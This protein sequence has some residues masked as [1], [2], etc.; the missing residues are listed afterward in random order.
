MRTTFF[1][2]VLIIACLWMS[3]AWGQASSRPCSE[4]EE[5]GPACLIGHRN[6]SAVRSEPLFW[7]LETFRSVRAAQRAAGPNGTVVTAYGKTWLFTI[8]RRQWRS[9]GGKH[10]AAIGPLAL[11]PAPAYSVHYL[12]AVFNPGMTAPLHV[13][14]GPEAFYALTGDSCLETP[15]GAQVARGRGNQLLV[16]GGPPMLL[17]ALGTV[18]RRGFA[19]IVHDARRPAT[20]LINDWKPEGLCAREFARERGERFDALRPPLPTNTGTVPPSAGADA[21]ALEAIPREFS[22]AWANGDG[23]A[24][25]R[26]MASDV[27]FVTVGA[28]WLHGRRDF[29]LYHSRLFEGRFRGSII[30]PLQTRVRFIRPDLAIVRWSWRIA[31]DRSPDGSLQQARVGLMSMLVEKRQ[32]HWLVIGSQNTN[33]TPGTVPEE[34]GINFP[35][36]LPGH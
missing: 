19:A 20:T 33:G 34:D 25:G 1:G 6:L 18:P 16:R 4:K 30:T 27:D 9:R 32:G 10:V 3:P 26:L 14:S 35:I 12:R 13:H 2:L 11:E 29:T 23:E 24:L 15:D 31:G 5:V 22:S 36:T 17:M 28:T 7:H 8:E 21:A